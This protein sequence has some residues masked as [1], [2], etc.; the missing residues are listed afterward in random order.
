MQPFSDW[1]VS[2]YFYLGTGT[3]SV[4]TNATSARP[5]NS[6]NQFSNVG[7]GIRGYISKRTIAR[8]EYGEYILFSADSDTD[9]NMGANEW[10]LGLAVFF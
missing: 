3:I 7:I 9:L 6:D 1:R 8:F 5:K 2:P 10:K 4:S